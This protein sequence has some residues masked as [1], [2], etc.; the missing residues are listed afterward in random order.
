MIVQIEGDN[1]TAT[2]TTTAS[3]VVALSVKG[4]GGIN[5]KT[6]FKLTNLTGATLTMYYKID[7]YISNHPDCAATAIKAET[8]IANATPVTNTDTSTPYA[9]VVVSVKNNSGACAYQIDYLTY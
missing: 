5:G 1:G 9:K 8:S 4:Y 3:Y 2:G 7:G 6:I